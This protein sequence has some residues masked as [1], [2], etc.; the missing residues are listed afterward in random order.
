M[1]FF[2]RVIPAIFGILLFVVLLYLSFQFLLCFFL[3]N[4]IVKGAVIRLV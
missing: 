3:E 4:T 2:D 1:I